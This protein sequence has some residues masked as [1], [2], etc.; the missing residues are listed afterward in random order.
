MTLLNGSTRHIPFEGVL[1][2]R[3]LGGY[4]T[5]RGETP[6]R[7]TLRAAS[8]H[9]LSEAEISSLETLGLTRVIDLRYASETDKQPNP[10]AARKGNVAYQGISLFSGL[11]PEHPKFVES[12]NPLLTL[13][14]EAV[15]T[16]PEGFVDVMRAIAA[17]GDGA[18]LFHCTAGKDR[19]GLIA[20]ML[21]QLA[22]VSREDIVADYALTADH[23][24]PL[25]EETRAAVT[26]D[27][28]DFS[29]IA[30]YFEARAETIGDFLDYFDST[31]GGAR[32]YLA[33]NGLSD[34]ELDA[35][36]HRLHA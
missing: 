33:A 15:D 32:A 9:R 11:D 19:T 8:L 27:G 25:I 14:I 6:W 35:L 21:L 17:S 36:A 22:G 20:A 4:P 12:D 5:P 16:M 2:L 13:Y 26:A 30:P 24:A 1:N 28:G 7:K 31:H 18:V 10:F 29:R 23:L 3:D 34:A